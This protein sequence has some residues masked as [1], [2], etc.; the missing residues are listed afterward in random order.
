MTVNPDRDRIAAYYNNLVEQHGYSVEARDS[1]R[2]E[3]LL[4]RYK[5]LN[6]V[7]NLAGKR[8]LEVGCGF[9]DLGAYLQANAPGVQYVGIDISARMIDEGRK[10]HPNLD[11]RHA[12]VL[13]W[14]PE[15]SFDVVMAQGIFYL[16]GEDAE[17]K[18]LKLI[19]TMYELATEA[20]AFCTLSGWAENKHPGE[21]FADPVATLGFCRTLTKWVVLRHEYLPNDFCIYLYRQAQ[22]LASPRA[23]GA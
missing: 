16:L 15:H 17:R 20:A 22:F 14:K 6:G 1:T 11:I 4:A 12:D 7:A 9:G 3:L 2:E 10:V 5:V 21:Y 8:V 23:G 19:A 18:S 13:S